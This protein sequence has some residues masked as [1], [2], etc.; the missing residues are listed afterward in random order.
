MCLCELHCS[1]EIDLID[2]VLQYMKSRVV[3]AAE[4]Q[5]YGEIF[6]SMGNFVRQGRIRFATAHCVEVY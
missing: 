2:L 1:A 4:C 6:R 5:S 3:L